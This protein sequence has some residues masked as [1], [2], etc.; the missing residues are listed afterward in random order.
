MNLFLCKQQVSCF[1]FFLQTE[2]FFGKIWQSKPVFVSNYFLGDVSVFEQASHKFHTFGSE[3]LFQFCNR[4]TTRRGRGRYLLPF[5]KNWKKV[6]WFWENFL[7]V[8][9][10]GCN[11]LFKMQFLRIFFPRDLFSLCCRWNIC[12]NALI[13]SYSP[14]LKNNYLCP[15][16]SRLFFKEEVLWVAKVPCNQY[17]GGEAWREDGS[18]LQGSLIFKAY[19]DEPWNVL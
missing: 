1:G 16:A 9:I 11:V 17:V 6:S 7:I 2:F 8:S 18:S 12:R 4:C 5:F 3:I 14:A 10:Y 15:W 19:I 13:P